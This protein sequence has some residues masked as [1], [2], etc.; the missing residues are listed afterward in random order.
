MTEIYPRDA[1]GGSPAAVTL[2]QMVEERGDRFLFRKIQSLNNR[3][4]DGLEELLKMDDP[5]RSVALQWWRSHVLD[6]STT[7]RHDFA[8]ADIPFSYM[9]NVLSRRFNQA[10]DEGRVLEALRGQSDD[11]RAIVAELRLMRREQNRRERGGE[12]L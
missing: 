10:I 3:F 1:F 12:E 2:L 4:S 7:I 6:N 5:M 11:F 8:R 9:D